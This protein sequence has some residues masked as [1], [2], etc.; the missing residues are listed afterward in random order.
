MT[1]PKDKQ[2]SEKSMLDGVIKFCLYYIAPEDKLEPE[3]KK[4]IFEDEIKMQDDYFHIGNYFQAFANT[5]L[6]GFQNKVNYSTSYA[7]G[8]IVLRNI[9]SR[10][11]DR[12]EK[13]DERLYKYLIDEDIDF[14][15]GETKSIFENSNAKHKVIL[16][17][18]LIE[19][20][21]V[22]MLKVGNV[23]MF[24]INEDYIQHIPDTIPSIYIR[25]SL[26]GSTR[27]DAKKEK[28]L[29]DNCKYIAME[30][31]T[32]GCHFNSETSSPV[33][34]AIEE[35]KQVWA[36][37]YMCKHYLSR[38][39]EDRYEIPVKEIK[40]SGFL[41]QGESEISNFYV[42]KK[43]TAEWRSVNTQFTEI[44]L[45]KEKFVL[46][47][48]SVEEI[49]KRCC[50][51]QFNKLYSN[52]K[53]TFKNKVFTSLGWYLKSHQEVDTTDKAISLFI[54]L[55]SLLTSS[56]DDMAENVALLTY[57]T[58]DDRYK[59]KKN[60]K[61]TVYPLRNKILH[62]GKRVNSNKDYKVLRELQDYTVWS[63]RN[64]LNRTERISALDAGGDAIKEYFERLKL[65]G[66]LFT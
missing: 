46:D 20:V 18:N 22:S 58:V 47:N 44:N 29:E 4:Y 57:S 19:F 14:A 63:L 21:D 3:S 26:L 28:F 37:L 8:D 50:L 16:V 1:M 40:N 32:K 31:D 59:A 45:S 48:K 51:E 17:T 65:S 13:I 15:I 61:D 52:I 7:V 2:L 33:E 27:E 55:E 9:Y 35:F 6:K 62:S 34:T 54:S 56:T 25:A 5:Y 49:K 64:I 12:N 42:N 43:D 38:V 11:K 36:Y 39:A 60:F 41:L 23:K 24:K 10:I 66:V 53:G 30:I